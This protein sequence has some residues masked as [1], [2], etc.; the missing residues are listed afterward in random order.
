LPYP[1]LR[2]IG[3]ALFETTKFSS[4]LTGKAFLGSQK[5]LTDEGISNVKYRSIYFVLAGIKCA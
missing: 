5:D 2:Q 1:F 4:Y 3:S